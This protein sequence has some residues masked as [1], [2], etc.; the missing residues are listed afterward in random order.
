MA[1]N[2]FLIIVISSEAEL[3]AEQDHVGAAIEIA[4]G[5]GGLHLVA[6]LGKGKAVSIRALIAAAHHEVE[7]SRYA[8]RSAF[9]SPSG[10]ITMPALCT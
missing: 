4:G 3:R 2:I 8:A 5:Q 9:L 6:G 10:R 1:T 7:R